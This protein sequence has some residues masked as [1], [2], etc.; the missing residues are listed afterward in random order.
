MHRSGV[1]AGRKE[2]KRK[3]EAMQGG[4]SA[5]R[6]KEQEGKKEGFKQGG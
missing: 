4:K 2:G 1:I 3:E 5:A 6:R